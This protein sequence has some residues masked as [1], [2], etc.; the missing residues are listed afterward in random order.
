MSA[1]RTVILI[2][3][4]VLGAVAAFATYSWLN[5][6]QDRA[7]AD[8][9]LVKVFRVSKDIEKGVAGEQ[10]L[11]Q[12]AIKSDDAPQEFRPATALT[13]INAIRG[14]VALTKLSAGQIVVDGMFVDPRV[15]QVTAA[16]RIP[17]GQVAVTV[18]VDQVKAVGGLLVAGDK[19]NI[20]VA[21][22]DG[23]QRFLYQNVNIIQIGDVAAPQAGETQ[24]VAA[25]TGSSGLITF[26]VPPAAAERIVLATSTGSGLY[27]TLVPPDNRPVPIPPVNPG[28]L[29]QTGLTPYEG[30]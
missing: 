14:K 22:P 13:D 27:L 5:G 12:E 23:G 17:A 1:R 11:S 26:A 16:Q 18:S 10:A 9:K 2:V 15:A 3:A 21:T 6:V 8:S 4:I 24:A 29:F 25:P 19:V 28:N 20:L 7:Y 30:Q